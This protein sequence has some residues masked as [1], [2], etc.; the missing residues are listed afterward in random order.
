MEHLL[1]AVLNSNNTPQKHMSTY[2]IGP[3]TVAE[4]IIIAAH[5]VAM[6]REIG[7]VPTEALGAQLLTD[8]TI[9]LASTPIT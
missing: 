9:A 1:H 3:A 2:T 5:R 7:D 8:S 6:F 4:N